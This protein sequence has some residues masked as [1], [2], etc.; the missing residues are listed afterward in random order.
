M[1]RTK[2]IVDVLPTIVVI[3]LALAV[4][5]TGYIA[6]GTDTRPR[7]STPQFCRPSD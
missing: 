3:V 4:L 7:C 1:T 6:F 2:R 5:A